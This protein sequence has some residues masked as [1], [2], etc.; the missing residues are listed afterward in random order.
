MLGRGPQSPLAKIDFLAYL[1]EIALAQN[2]TSGVLGNA[3]LELNNA[4]EYVGEFV[5]IVKEEMTVKRAVESRGEATIV[6]YVKSTLGDESDTEDTENQNGLWSD[7]VKDVFSRLLK[8][9]HIRSVDTHTLGRF[10]STQAEIMMILLRRL[11]N[12]GLLMRS[13][14]SAFGLGL[15]HGKQ[16]TMLQLLGMVAWCEQSLTTT[17]PFGRLVGVPALCSSVGNLVGFENPFK[18]FQEITERP[19]IWLARYISYN[20]LLIDKERVQVLFCNFRL[21]FPE[22]ICLGP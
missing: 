9:S 5:N 11:G 19:E 3:R 13:I 2:A 14:G 17:L 20:R 15:T 21:R 7:A 8:F 10:V 22:S 16:P 12:L 18:V 6:I 1:C 4:A